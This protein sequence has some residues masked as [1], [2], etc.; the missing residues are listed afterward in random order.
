MRANRADEQ[1]E[2]QNEIERNRLKR[3]KQHRNFAINP[4]R[5]AFNYS[6]T[7]DYSSRQIVAI[8]PINFV[9]P[10]CKA[11]KFKNEI[12]GLCSVSGQ[13]KLTSLVPPP[14]PLRSSVSGNRPDSIHFL[15]YIQLYNN[16]FQMTSFSATKVI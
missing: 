10:H 2:K 9:C 4:H 7:I 5:T 16:C 14:E 13:V 12:P 8:G 11:F 6:V 15:T 3:N 1:R